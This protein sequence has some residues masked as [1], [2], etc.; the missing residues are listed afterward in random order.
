LQK[1]TDNIFTETTFQGCNSSFIVT[2]EGAVVI[3]T[4]MVPVEAREWKTRIESHAPVRYVIINEAHIDHYCGCCYLEG[5]VIGTEDTYSALKNAKIEEFIGALSMLAPDSPKPDQN[6]YFRPPEITIES[7]GTL[8][9]GDHTIRILSVPGHTPQ[10]LAVHVPEERVLF[11]SDNINLEIP[12]FVSALPD[13]WIKALNRLSELDVDFV[14]P[15]HGEVSD[16]SVIQQMKDKIQLWIQVVGEAI[17]EGL[18]LEETRQRIMEAKEF[19]DIPR[20]ESMAGFVN[21]N[22]ESLYRILKQHYSFHR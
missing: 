15:G 6:F 17:K 1:I 4:P 11:T 10:Q 9:L 14:I 5:T 19:S 12:T 20:E 18:E 7:E 16:N 3:D 21:M 2:K 22:I 8:H 13:E